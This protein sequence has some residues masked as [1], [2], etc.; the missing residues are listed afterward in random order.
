MK[1]TTHPRPGRKAERPPEHEPPRPDPSAEGATISPPPLWPPQNGV[2]QRKRRKEV[3]KEY[4]F[5]RWSGR[6]RCRQERR[7]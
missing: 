5:Q 4:Y 6:M 1:G 2:W 7:L 3:K